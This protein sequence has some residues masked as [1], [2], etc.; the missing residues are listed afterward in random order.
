MATEN[1]S[2]RQN[3]S[4]W[5]TRMGILVQIVVVLLPP[6]L[7]LHSGR[8]LLAGFFISILLSWLA[9]KLRKQHWSDVGLRPFSNVNKIFLIAITSTAILIPLSYLLRQVVTSATHQVSNL[10][11]FKIIHGNVTALITGVG[12]VWIFGAFA[13][14]MFFRGFLMNSFYK[15]LPNDLGDR[16]KWIISLVVTSLLVA[17]G[18]TYQGITGMVLTALIGFCF[19]LI[20]LKSRK[21][22]WPGIL[23][24]GLYDT[25]A[26]VMVFLGFNFDHLFK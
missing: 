11:Q 18:H 15:L 4:L 5:N 10:E 23:T 9:L 22:L 21:N 13:E 12:V 16:L 3:T 7:L 26:L 14:E 20:Y 19:G 1:G 8:L 2:N 17:F 24:H 6:A 25:I